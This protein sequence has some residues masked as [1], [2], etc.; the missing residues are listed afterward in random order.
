ML[1]DLRLARERAGESVWQLKTLVKRLNEVEELFK[2]LK[3][4]RV[5]ARERE[6]L[7]RLGAALVS[8]REECVR[9]GGLLLAS[10]SPVRS[11]LQAGADGSN[12]FCAAAEEQARAN[13]HTRKRARQR[14]AAHARHAAAGAGGGSAR[15]TLG[16]NTHRV[17]ANRAATAAL[18]ATA[19]P[20]ATTPRADREL[21]P[22]PLGHAPGGSGKAPQ[23]RGKGAVT[24]TLTGAAALPG[25]SGSSGGANHEKQQHVRSSR[26]AWGSPQEQLRQRQRVDAAG[27]HSPVNLA[28][29][30]DSTKAPAGCS[31]PR[32]EGLSY[33][34]EEEEMFVEQ[35]PQ[36][37][38]PGAEP[39]P[40]PRR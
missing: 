8:Q 5:C 3:G 32:R 38:A 15:G 31:A 34:S 1:Y 33:S 2:E 23:D 25:R 37:P 21:S 40:V 24:T 27:K 6:Q 14:R 29:R 26:A 17:P 12:S 19:A 11:A 30:F 35:E 9:Q 18:R 7:A 36:P 22:E 20:P 39:P 28:L 13:A 4:S 10:L 16:S